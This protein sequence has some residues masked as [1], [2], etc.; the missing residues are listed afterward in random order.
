MTDGSNPG[1][2][3]TDGMAAHDSAEHYE[4]FHSETCGFCHR[5]R[6]YFAQAGWE[7]PLRDVNRDRDARAELMAGGG[8]TMVPCLKITRGEQVTWMYESLDIIDYLEQ[9]RAAAG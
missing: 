3:Q 4:L 9:Q 6:H 5:V 8:R 1:T 7:I 2:E